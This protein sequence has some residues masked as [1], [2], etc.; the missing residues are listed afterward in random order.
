MDEAEEVG[1]AAEED[2]ADADA[3]E[4]ADDEPEPEVD[5]AADV[6]DRST[7]ALDR[8]TEA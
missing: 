7:V 3:D 4:E 6:D 2:K 5:D 8:V 1:P